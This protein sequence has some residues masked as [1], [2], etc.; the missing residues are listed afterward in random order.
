MKTLIIDCNAMC[1]R[2]LYSLPPDFS[3]GKHDTN[4]IFGFLK[5]I[6]KLAAEFE[7][8]KF[9]FCWDSKKSYR[10]LIYPDYKENRNK[11]PK[12][13][14]R[15]KKA[16]PQFIELQ[17]DVLPWMGFKNI[18][19]QNGYEADDLI[20]YLAYR[21]PRD[22][23][24]VSGD[25]DLFQLLYD[26]PKIECM[27]YNHKRL[28][29]A[30]DLRKHFGIEANDWARVKAIAGCNTD[31]VKG[32]E[33]VGD[34]KAIAYLTG[35]LPEGKIKSRIE[36]SQDLID[37]NLKLVALPYSGIQDISIDDPVGETFY[38][39]EFMEV[40]REYGMASQLAENVFNEW[41]D[42]FYCQAG[43]AKQVKRV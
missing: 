22:Y 23:V 15:L 13:K 33:G 2:S 10:K 30:Q 36:A 26:G 24:I 37:F 11:D 5:Q 31:N 3:F 42:L 40:F 41:C 27:M 16:F 19:S 25:E 20:A 32:V 35:V 39:V 34:L 18:Y 8:N 6:K 29:R 43:R 7:T 1:Y 17:E 38:R 21:F 28:T 4:I 14:E 12:V 9:F